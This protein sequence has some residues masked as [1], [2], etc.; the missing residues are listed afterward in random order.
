MKAKLKRVV[1][2]VLFSEGLAFLLLISAG[3]GAGIA[4]T[5]IGRVI[6]GS[7][8]DFRVPLA[9]DQEN[10]W[11]YP[12]G[13]HL[14]EKQRRNL[15]CEAAA[16]ASAA[17][18]AGW[19]EINEDIIL[20]ETPR[21]WNPREGFVGNPNGWQTADLRVLQR[22]RTSG[23][24]VEAPA[25]S[26]VMA[27]FGISSYVIEGWGFAETV[28]M[29]HSLRLEGKGVVIWG[30]TNPEWPHRVYSEPWRFVS[31][32]HTYEFL[33][34]TTNEEGFVDGALVGDPLYGTI[35]TIP[36]GYVERMMG[37]FDNM[38]LVIESPSPEAP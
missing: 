28:N 15:T 16:T 23:Y 11:V 18:S 21:S 14:V 17:I 33:S 32:E 1:L 37:Y 20:A 29:L 31:G 9:A 8:A 34:L 10:L 38:A 2:R 35:Y 12:A 27:Q 19:Q 3:S 13:G 22:D 24:G 7:G 30:T 6:Q 36:I 4:M 25:I 26:L 5:D